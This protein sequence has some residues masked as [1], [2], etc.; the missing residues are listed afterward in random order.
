MYDEATYIKLTLVS[1]AGLSLGSF[2]NTCAYRLPRNIS[3]IAPRSFCPTCLNTIHWTG[4]IPV[5]GY[6]LARGLCRDCGA[7]ITL[8]YP[9]V[10]LMVC[11]LAI[12]LYH[13]HGIS[14]EFAVSLLFTSSMVLIA[15]TDLSHRIIPDSIFVTAC[16]LAVF[17]FSV[18]SDADVV[19]SR[20]MTAVL[21]CGIM[22]TIRTVGNLL[23]RKETMGLGDVKLGLMLGFFLELHEFILALWLAAFIGSL[24]GFAGMALLGWTRETKL[25]LGSFLAVS[26]VTLMLLREPLN[27]WLAI[28]STLQP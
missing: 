21:C 3:L 23:L 22:M 26:V 6:L 1:L 20:F 2:L 9:I 15:L 7:R 18:S 12:V 4:L 5:F 24:V 16:F 19:A 17:L 10:E 27:E 11:G 28:W 13:R 14:I 8:R 25:P